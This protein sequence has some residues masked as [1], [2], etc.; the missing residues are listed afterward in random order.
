LIGATIALTGAFPGL[1]PATIPELGLSARALVLQ[2][3]LI[4]VLMRVSV[5]A[6]GRGVLYRFGV[7]DEMVRDRNVGAGAV[8]AGGCIAAGFVLHGALSGNSDSKWDALRDLLVFWA[9]GMVILIGGAWLYI[10][11]VK[12]DVEKVLEK[13]NN[14]AAGF[15]LGGFLIAVGITIN[16]SLVGASSNLGAELLLTLTASLIGL[17]LL[18][19]SAIIAA[20]VFLSGSPVSKEIAVDR[21]PAAGLISGACYVAMAVLLARVIAW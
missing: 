17:A 20:H 5:W 21:N 12:Y 13:D 1:A 18:V 16:A 6:V 19:C 2:G 9:A 15:S 7:R 3:V 4:A 8:L 14:A 10:H 11:V